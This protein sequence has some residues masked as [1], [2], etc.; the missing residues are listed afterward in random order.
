V[1]KGVV[2]EGLGLWWV[3]ATLVALALLA[4]FRE[5]IWLRLRPHGAKAA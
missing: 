1:A 3:H 5:E 2:S 4:L